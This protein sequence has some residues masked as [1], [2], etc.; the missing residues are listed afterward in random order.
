MS[1]SRIL[2]F[3]KLRLKS[4]FQAEFNSMKHDLEER[5]KESQNELKVATE[6]INKLKSMTSKSNVM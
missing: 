3:Y 1:N 2:Y 5:L 6:E 4:K